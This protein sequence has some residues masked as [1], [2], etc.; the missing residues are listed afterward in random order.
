MEKAVFLAL[1]Q[2]VQEICT[3]FDEDLAWTDVLVGLECLWSSFH[4]ALLRLEALAM[5]GDT[6]VS[7]KAVRQ[8]IASAVEVIVQIS[9]IS[10]GARK[11]MAISEVV[12]VNEDGTYKTED[13]YRINSLVRQPDGRLEGKIEP[14][15]ALP[16]FMK[17]IEDNRIPFARS[18]FFANKKAS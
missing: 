3:Q 4:Q 10:G 15:G 17:E 12:G 6:K 7:E 16:S 18:K 11:V 13:I 2:L 8:S 9:R 5:G 1:S 14:C